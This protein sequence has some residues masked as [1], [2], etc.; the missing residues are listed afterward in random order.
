MKKS[1]RKSNAYTKWMY[2]ENSEEVG[3][4]P[5]ELFWNSNVW[6]IGDEEVVAEEIKEGNWTDGKLKKFAKHLCPDVLVI[7]DDGY[8]LKSVFPVYSYRLNRKQNLRLVKAFM[9]DGRFCDPTNFLWYHQ[10]DLVRL[11]GKKNYKRLWLLAKA[12]KKY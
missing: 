10:S 12:S 11:L 1:E 4:T 6:L 8:S 9:L 5:A 2:I 3:L 7:G